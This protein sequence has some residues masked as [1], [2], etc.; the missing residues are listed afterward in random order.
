ME[1]KQEYSNE[2]DHLLKN[3]IFNLISMNNLG[4]KKRFDEQEKFHSRALQSVKIT[5]H[6]GFG[7]DLRLFH[8]SNRFFHPSPCKPLNAFLLGYNKHIFNIQ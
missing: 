5:K 7:L 8:I 1:S 3:E 6:V 2:D 4:N